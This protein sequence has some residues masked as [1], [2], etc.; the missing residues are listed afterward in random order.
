MG[1]CLRLHAANVA[2]QSQAKSRGILGFRIEGLEFRAR[3]WELSKVGDHFW[4]SLI[5]KKVNGVWRTNT[6]GSAI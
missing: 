1:S 3:I 6:V 2:M 4:R 5:N